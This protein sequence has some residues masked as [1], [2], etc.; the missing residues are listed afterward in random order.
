M[1]E[2][3][4]QV[5]LHRLDQVDNQLKCI[6]AEVKKTNGRVTTLET[7]SAFW[8]G[9]EAARRPLTTIGVGT[10]TGA[11]LATIIWF[12]SEAI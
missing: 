3:D 12:V 4:I 6:H 5:I 7:Q 10:I 8:L 1:S 9:K 2:S 11:L